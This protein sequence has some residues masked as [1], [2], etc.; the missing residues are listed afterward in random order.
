MKKGF[1]L[2]ELLAVISILAILV[3][4]ALP[5]VMGMFNQAKQNSFTTEIKEIYKVAQQTWMSDSMFDTGDR[6][7]A[8]CDNS[9][10]NKLDLSGREELHYYI[11]INKAGK[12]VEFSATDGTYQYEYTGDDLKIEDI[13][14]ITQIASID[15]NDK[16]IIN[17]NGYS[18]GT[19]FTGYKYFAGEGNVSLNQRFPS[20]NTYNTYQ[21]ATAAI[22]ENFFIRLNVTNS[23]VTEMDFGYILNGNVYYLKGLDQS[24]YESN[25]TIMLNSF[26]SSNCSIEGN[27]NTLNCHGTGISQLHISNAEKMQ[28]NAHRVWSCC[29]D[30]EY[31]NCTTNWSL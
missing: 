1:T 23:I 8:R 2:V 16:V 9:C 13:S 31:T 17:C 15:E 24:Y 25:K 7:Y 12:V 29:V 20:S 4:I 30:P 26:G 5:N 19:P 3:I 11:K 6:S 27:G 10:P 14:G 18:V 21:E 22:G 28:I